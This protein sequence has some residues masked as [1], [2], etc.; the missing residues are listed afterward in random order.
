MSDE[1]VTW[2]E[3]GTSL[4]EISVGDNPAPVGD[5]QEQAVGC[6]TEFC[7]N[8]EENSKMEAYVVIITSSRDGTWNYVHFDYGGGTGFS[9]RMPMY[10]KD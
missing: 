3:T 2:K 5:E 10:T 6:Y 7:K 4:V 9:L 8:K 1:F